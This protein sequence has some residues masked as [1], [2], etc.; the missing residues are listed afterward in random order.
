MS[1]K[2]FRNIINNVS[3]GQ[4]LGYNQTG[5]FGIGHMSGGEIRGNAKISG[6]INAAVQQDLTQSTTEIQQLLE[7][8]STIYPTET[9]TQKAVVVEKTIENIESNP[10][11]KQKMVSAIKAMGIEAFME[12]IDHPIANVLRAGIE[13]YQ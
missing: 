5:N 11:L 12:A 4:S 13:V 7:Q 9:L 3:G 1:N 8:L 10:T 6:I 2:K